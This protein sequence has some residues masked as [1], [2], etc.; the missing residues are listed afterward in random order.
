M[1]KHVNYAERAERAKLI[2]DLH[3]IA[4]RWIDTDCAVSSV[5]L[6]TIAALKAG[7]SHE[8][9]IYLLDFSKSCLSPEMKNRITADTNLI[10]RQAQLVKQSRPTIIEDTS[11]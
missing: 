2:L 1:T 6:G 8:L 10:G 9:A 4:E 7:V 5:I 11:K 3:S